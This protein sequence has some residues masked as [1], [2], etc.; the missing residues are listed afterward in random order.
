[1]DGRAGLPGV[2]LVDEARRVGDVVACGKPA[3]DRDG[4]VDLFVG[5][6]GVFGELNVDRH[7]DTN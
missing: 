1:M 5:V 7:L 6:E 4:R 3:D 2:V